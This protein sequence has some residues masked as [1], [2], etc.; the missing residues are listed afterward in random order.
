[1]SPGCPRWSLVAEHSLN[2][3]HD[4]SGAGWTKNFD[5]P[6]V[7]NYDYLEGYLR[8]GLAGLDPYARMT[9]PTLVA[10]I[11]L[12]GWVVRDNPTRRPHQ[13]RT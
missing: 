6:V 8:S 1:M 12:F 11:G 10:A 4:F 7:E 2:G 3:F 9:L 13:P 5:A